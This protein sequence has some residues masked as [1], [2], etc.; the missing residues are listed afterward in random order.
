MFYITTYEVVAIKEIKNYHEY[1]PR[2]Q[3]LCKVLDVIEFDNQEEMFKHSDS[4]TGENIFWRYSR[5]KTAKEYFEIEHSRDYWFWINEV[6]RNKEMSKDYYIKYELKK[7]ME[8]FESDYRTIYYKPQYAEIAKEI[9]K[10]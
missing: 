5:E 7:T 8:S 9:F 3:A 6:S 10:I 2:D 1:W 4:I